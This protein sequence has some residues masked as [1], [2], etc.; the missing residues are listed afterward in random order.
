MAQPRFAA[1]GAKIGKASRGRTPV[2]TTPFAIRT[3]GVDLPKGFAEW[4]RTDLAMKLRHAAPLIL[5]GTVRFEDVNGP[6]GGTDTVCRIKL[7]V[8]GRPSIQVEEIAANAQAAFA[9]ALPVVVRAVRRVRGKHDLHGGR[10]RAR[11]GERAARPIAPD[12]GEIIGRRV[13]RGRDALARAL[14]RPEKLRRD[15]YVDT[16]LPGTSASD[17]RAG[18]G[19]TARRNTL[20]RPRRATAALEDSRTKPSRK[21]TRRSANHGKPSQ[22]KERTALSRALTP[23]A[24][25]Q[26]RG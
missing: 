14:A 4:I 19:M 12:D 9:L 2:E 1:G 24:K 8:S 11:R 15:A 6:K 10:P 3:V 25:S 23:S 5:R 17:R 22:G 26:R 21:S 20:A 7:V 13:G 16:S 18:G